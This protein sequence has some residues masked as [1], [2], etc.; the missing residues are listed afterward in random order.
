YSRLPLECPKAAVRITTIATTRHDATRPLATIDCDQ[1]EGA[2][3]QHLV[4][5]SI[6]A[7]RQ[8]GWRPSP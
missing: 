1:Y 3:G 2:V 5:L 7:W 4:I 8:A 6:L